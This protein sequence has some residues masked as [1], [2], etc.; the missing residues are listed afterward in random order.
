MSRKLES[1]VMVVDNR[2]SALALVAKQRSQIFDSEICYAS[3]FVSPNALLNFLLASEKPKILFAW[4]GA[5]R[6]TLVSARSTKR[7]NKLLELKTVHMLVPDLLGIDPKYLISEARLVNMTHGYWVT[8][9]ELRALYTKHFPSRIPSGVLHDIPDIS[10]IL[11]IRKTKL[12]RSGIIWVGN[13]QWGTNHGYFDHKG[14]VKIVQPLSKMRLPFSPFRIRDS[15]TNRT[16]NDQLLHEIAES[17][18]LIQASTHEGTGLPLLEALGVGTVPI[19]TDV[20]IA[21]EVLEGKLEQLITE[22]DVESF[23]RGIERVETDL[24]EL[25]FLCSSAFDKFI[26]RIR[27]EVIEWDRR[28]IEVNTSD[29]NFLF[30]WKIRL[31]WL[32]RFF[33]MR[34]MR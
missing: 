31:I 16:P 26:D 20:G 32:Y 17:E 7:Y 27:G 13:T 25:S 4:R 14:Y 10:L 30:V 5:L 24:R 22:R 2:N 3:D 21:R 8:S 33:Q 15:H 1:F 9:Q 23:K 6:E 11:E 29:E 34:R 18:I 12:S 19:T 28:G